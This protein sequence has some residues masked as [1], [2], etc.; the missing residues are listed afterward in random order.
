MLIQVRNKENKKIYSSDMSADNKQS[1]IEI[2]FCTSYTQV[3]VQDQV[4]E[5]DF[6]TK[7][8]KIKFPTTD[9]ILPPIGST[10]NWIDEIAT[11]GNHTGE[12]VMQSPDVHERTEND[13]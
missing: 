9:L 13:T 12:W 10:P 8:T 5:I 11:Q 3:I 1:I 2:H 4:E 7:D 6:L